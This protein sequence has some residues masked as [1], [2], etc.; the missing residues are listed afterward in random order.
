MQACLWLFTG[1]ETSL[2]PDALSLVLDSAS[3]HSY[4]GYLVGGPSVASGSVV[5]TNTGAAWLMRR[6]VIIPVGLHTLAAVATLL[7]LL[8]Y[9]IPT[10]NVFKGL[11]TLLI[12]LLAGWYVLKAVGVRSKHPTR[13]SLLLNCHYST[14]RAPLYWCV[15]TCLMRCFRKPS[16]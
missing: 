7:W 2:E 13:P 1:R 5:S 12:L 4:R 6:S 16:A 11:T 9:F 14:P 8:W 15:V 10:G 3:R